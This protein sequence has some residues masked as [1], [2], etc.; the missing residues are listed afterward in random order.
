MDL[1]LKPKQLIATLIMLVQNHDPSAPLAINIKSPPGFGKSSMVAQVAKQLQAHLTDVRAVL[2]DPVD[3]RGLPYVANGVSKWAVPDFLPTAQTLSI[4]LLD[5]LNRA[6]QMVQNACLQL[7]LDRRL[8]DYVVPDKTVIITC[9]NPTGRGVQQFN[10]A[11]NDRFVHI[12]LVADLDDLCDYFNSFKKFGYDLVRAYLRWRPAAV[13]EFDPK[14][15]K[16]PSPRSWEFAARIADM[17]IKDPA[18]STALYAGAVGTGRGIEL[19]AFERTFRG[20]PAPD[21]IL[22]NPHAA[23]V[24]QTPDAQ[25]A[26]SVALARLATDQNFDAVATYAERLP[27]EFACVILHDAQNTDPAIGSHPAYT[28]LITT[29]KPGQ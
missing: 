8:G 16:N 9:T 28:R 6:P 26:V 29:L 25:Y 5:E 2:L 22:L 19:A 1:R 13:S 3:L 11:L 15:T 14:A 10:E 23:M 4:L 20:I 12:E 17:Q 18:I 27:R 24:P 21:S 7:V